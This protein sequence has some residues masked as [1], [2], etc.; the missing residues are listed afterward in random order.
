L[1]AAGW[2]LAKIDRPIVEHYPDEGSA[3]RLLLRRALN[4]NA[5]ALGELLRAAIGHEH[6][7]FIVGKDRQYLLCLL[8]TSWW[9]ALVLAAVA[10]SG[11]SAVL[12]V[13][14]LLLL[15]FAAMSLRWRSVRLGLYS[16]TAWNVFTFCSW[17]GLWRPRTSPAGW[18]DSTVLQAPE[19]VRPHQAHRPLG[20]GSHAHAPDADRGKSLQ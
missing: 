14:A 10:L 12:A 17:L 1:H 8:V 6:F 20:N 18:I 4:K 19:D 7:W 3:Y 15:P 13:G 11:W 5:Y 2:I 9:I 16:I